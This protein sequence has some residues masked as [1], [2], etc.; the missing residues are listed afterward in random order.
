M[1]NCPVYRAWMS[2]KLDGLLNQEQER[3]LQ[4][5]L[6][7]CAACRAEW[8]AMQFISCLLEE[9]PV[10]PAPPGF[11]ARMERRLRAER[12]ARR[13]G[14]MGAAALV[15]GAL[16]LVTVGLSSL[17]GFVVWLWPLLKQPS[18]W[19]TAAGW[20]SRAADVGLAVGNA[21]ALLLGSLFNTAG[22]P[23]LLVYIL[24]VLLLTA[25]WSRLVFRRVRAYRP[26]RR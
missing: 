24:A 15:L 9:Q 13:R 20:L 5:H 22:G 4:A 7:T 23:I 8:A 19:D 6:A 14:V 18:L 17:A 11:V 3:A 2:L 21:V 12:A 26:V 10:V 16:S 1:P 25:L